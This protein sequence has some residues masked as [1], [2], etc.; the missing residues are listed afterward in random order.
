MGRL[1]GIDNRTDFA[2]QKMNHPAATHEPFRRDALM[3]RASHDE[4]QHGDGRALAQCRDWLTTNLPD[5]TQVPAPSTAAAAR[6]CQADARGAAIASSQA[7]RLHGLAVLRE[8]VQDRDDNV[9]R[10]LVIGH[11]GRVAIPAS[12]D[13]T[14]ILLALPHRAG[15]LYEVLGPLSEAAV[16]ISKIESRPSP[17]RS[18]AYV[19][20]LDLDGHVEQPPLK[21]ALELVAARCPLFRVLGCYQR[22][23][24]N[25]GDESMF[26]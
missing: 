10:F 26:A 15:A 7:A 14:S 5:A 11:A 8:R 19:F 25:G 3:L 22:L 18:W 16:H 2:L 23:T 20:F 9:T 6:S 13:R 21:T 12:A 4:R 1:D 17:G 24:P